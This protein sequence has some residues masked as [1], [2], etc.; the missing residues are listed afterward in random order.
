MDK[1]AER[2]QF[3]ERSPFT[4]TKNI[5]KLSDKNDKDVRPGKTVH[6]SMDNTTETEDISDINN[7]KKSSKKGNKRIRKQKENEKNETVGKIVKKNTDMV[8]LKISQESTR[9]DKDTLNKMSFEDL[10]NYNLTKFPWPIKN[11]YLAL[12]KIS[13]FPFKKLG[14]F[15]NK[16][17]KKTKKSRAKGIS[18]LIE[19]TLEEANELF[20]KAGYEDALIQWLAHYWNKNPDNPKRHIL[21]QSLGEDEVNRHLEE[22]KN[23]ITYENKLA[24]ELQQIKLLCGMIDE[25]SYGLDGTERE[26]WDKQIEQ[27]ALQF[28]HRKLHCL[29][30]IFFLISIL[31]YCYCFLLIVNFYTFYIRNRCK[32]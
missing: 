21:K 19:D 7:F 9:T 15:K 26:Q 4:L 10:E 17:P 13:D 1:K 18:D 29:V 28:K 22:L 32:K 30:R 20:T 8:Q 24:F 6:F 12:L 31:L 16:E 14:V 2:A 11:K 27:R 23:N 25:D 5:L 3:K